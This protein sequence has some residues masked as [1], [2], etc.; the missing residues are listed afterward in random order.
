MRV[1]IDDFELHNEIAAV[2]RDVPTCDDI[3]D[4][5]VVGAERSWFAVCTSG[6]GAESYYVIAGRACG[7]TQDLEEAFRILWE[8]HAKYEQQGRRD[9]P[10]VTEQPPGA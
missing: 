9:R 4:V 7:E 2:F 3:R 8:E 1:S 10:G 6:S 5:Y